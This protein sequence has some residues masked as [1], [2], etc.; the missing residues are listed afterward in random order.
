MKKAGVAVRSVPIDAAPA[1]LLD[2]I[3]VLEIKSARLTSDE[4][5]RERT[6]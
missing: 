6:R 2:R 4:Q 3:T 1:D 5:L